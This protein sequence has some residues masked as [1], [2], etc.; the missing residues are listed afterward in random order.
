MIVV[1]ALACSISFVFGMAWG[2]ASA[3]RRL[4]GY[5]YQHPDIGEAIRRAERRGG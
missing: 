5:L 3:R 1:Y 4:A 2:S